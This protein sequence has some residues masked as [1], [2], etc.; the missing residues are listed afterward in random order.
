M[1]FDEASTSFLDYIEVTR[2]DGTFRKNKSKVSGL[3]MFFEDCELDLID[4]KKIISF[5]RFRKEKNPKVSGTTLNMYIA[6]LK[7]IVK[8]NSNKILEFD[9]LP[10]NSK[11]PRVIDP[12][13]IEKVFNH[14]RSYFK[15][16]E[17]LRNLVLFKLLLDTGLRVNE[18]LNLRIRDIDMESNTIHVKIT[19]TKRERYVFFTDST[20]KILIRLLTTHNI[21]DY[22]FIN[23][24]AKKRLNVDAIQ[25]VC[26]RLEKRL[27]L[28]DRIRPHKWRHTF[29]TN[30]LKR[31]GD[32]ESL[33]LILGH[34]SLK[35][36]Q[37]YLHLDK[38]FLH[39]EYFKTL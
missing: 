14:L 17:S 1:K 26:F 3:L 10:E 19:K 25:N 33:R 28:P 16:K 8:Y 4:N 18:A 12:I 32:L 2:S 5:I 22:I 7:R 9:N 24:K 36:T 38:E 20:K 13:V 15:Y 39:D 35:T 21:K 37:R 31:G 34:S 30:F 27:D 11:I 29:A 6:T 23:Y